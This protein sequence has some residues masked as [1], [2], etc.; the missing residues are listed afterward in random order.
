V[1]LGAEEAPSGLSGRAF[2][3]PLLVFVAPNTARRDLAN[4]SRLRTDANS[5]GRVIRAVHRE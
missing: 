5:H 4:A 1:L 3:E 2:A